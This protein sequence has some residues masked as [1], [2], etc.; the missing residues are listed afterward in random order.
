MNEVFIPSLEQGMVRSN[1]TVTQ[2]H[3]VDMYNNIATIPFT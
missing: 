1:K 2:Y 3:R